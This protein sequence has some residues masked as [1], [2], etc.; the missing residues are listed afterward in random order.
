[1]IMNLEKPRLKN[2]SER[3]PIIDF[4]DATEFGGVGSSSLPEKKWKSA[5]KYPVIGQGE[6]EIQGW[7]DELRFLIRPDSPILLYGGHTRRVKFLK[8]NF[9]PGPNVKILRPYSF[10]LPKF[11][12]YYLKALS[13]AIPSKGYADHFPLVRKSKV[14]VAPEGE[15]KRIVSKVEELFSDVDAGTKALE[16]VSANLKRYRASVLKAACEGK[17]VTTEAESAKQEGREYEHASILLERILK[18]RKEKW[19]KENPGKK[20]KEPEAPDTDDLPELPEGWVW[21]TMDQLSVITGGITLNTSQR[22]SGKSY[23]YLRVANVYA[24]RLNLDEIKT[25]KV[26]DAELG[27]VLLQK[28]DLLIVEGN[29]S[30]EQIGR[31]ARWDGSIEKCVHQNHLIKARAEADLSNYLLIYLLSPI[32]RSEIMKVASS[33]SGLYTLSLSKVKSISVP[34]PPKTEI[35]RIELEVD[36]QDSLSSNTGQ[37]LG[38]KIKTI[39]TLKQSILKKAFNGELVE[40]DP[41]DEPASMLLEK[42][43][44]ERLKREA[45]T[46]PKKKAIKKSKKKS[47]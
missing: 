41:G 37:T 19:E 36:K 22:T 13:A 32:G 42:I 14:P 45:E 18:E 1:M 28:K 27:R 5:G 15:Q 39:Q 43:K 33:T 30:P 3:W 7:T 31:V 46:K 23:S 12:F 16:R 38:S 20:Y 6:G 17:L 29:G 47:S 9:V 40:Q 10:L 2:L 44:A 25:V 26:T 24:N 11:F 8:D 34:L 21:A 4:A 35:E